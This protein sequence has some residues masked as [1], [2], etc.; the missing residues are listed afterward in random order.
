MS[1]QV[2]TSHHPSNDY[3][4]G[5]VSKK[6]I[7]SCLLFHSSSSRH[8]GGIRTK[9]VVL[10]IKGLTKKCSTLCVEVTTC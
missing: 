10:V 5:R 9:A 7:I 3:D 6:K 8:K 2:F 4:K 1:L